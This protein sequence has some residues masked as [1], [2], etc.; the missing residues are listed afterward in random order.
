MGRKKLFCSAC[1]HGCSTRYL[2]MSPTAGTSK[3]EQHSTNKKKRLTSIDT[4]LYYPVPASQVT[5]RTSRK[6]LACYWNTYA[7][8][9]RQCNLSRVN[10]PVITHNNRRPSCNSIHITSMKTLRR[11]AYPDRT[12]CDIDRLNTYWLLSTI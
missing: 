5:A 4:I 2:T 12:K 11:T 8:V 3:H 10:T 9:H 7:R 6:E 1:L